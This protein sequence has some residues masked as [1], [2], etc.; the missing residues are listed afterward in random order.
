MA[1]RLAIGIQRSGD[2]MHGTVNE[3]THTTG[4]YAGFDR[5]G[6]VKDQYWEGYGTTDDVDRFQY[7]HDFASN[8]LTRENVISG[9]LGLS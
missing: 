8:R 4:T 7:G 2:G 3:I 5:F 9:G 1:G 6:R